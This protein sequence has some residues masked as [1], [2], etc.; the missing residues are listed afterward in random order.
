VPLGS[1]EEKAGEAGARYLEQIIF[2]INYQSGYHSSTSPLTFMDH[3][4][5]KA[6]TAA[7]RMCVLL[8]PPSILCA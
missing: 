4:V 6:V 3:R 2:E 1:Q 7:P 5:V 8:S